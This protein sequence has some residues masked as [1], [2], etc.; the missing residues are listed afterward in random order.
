M[1]PAEDLEAEAT[2]V[3]ARLLAG[4]AVAYAKTKQAINGAT[5]PDFDAALAADRRAAHPLNSADLREGIRAFQEKRD[6]PS[7]TADLLRFGAFPVAERRSVQ[8]ESPKIVGRQRPASVSIVEVST[9]T[10][11]QPARRAAPGG[12]RVLT[13]SGS[14]NTG[15]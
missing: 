3:I 11:R 6:P 10:D 1:H 8:P 4:P 5:L 9:Q 15:C 7:P 14:A 13:R 2:K 12:W